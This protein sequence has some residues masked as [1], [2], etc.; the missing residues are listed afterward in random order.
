MLQA[1]AHAS[2]TGGV[3]QG[4]VGLDWAQQQVREPSL[5]RVRE[6]MH[7]GVLRVAEAV[8]ESNEDGVL[9]DLP[10]PGARAVGFGTVAVMAASALWLFGHSGV[11]RMLGFAQGPDLPGVVAGGNG[12]DTMFGQA[13]A[14]SLE[15]RAG[16]DVLVGLGGAD[17]LSGGRGNDTLLGGQGDDVLWAGDGRDVLVGG[18]G[19]DTLHASAFDGL[20]DQLLCGAGKDVAH[21][22][23]VNGRIVEKTHGCERVVVTAVTV[24]ARAR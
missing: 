14:D 20:A 16:A 7:Y 6:T 4:M 17:T 8:R 5:R 15:G 2:R 18:A 23:S 22:V 21:V 11:D 13:R 12:A 10:R 9:A 3:G 1:S 24:R 19:N